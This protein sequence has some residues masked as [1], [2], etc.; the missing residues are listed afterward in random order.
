[1]TL[2]SIRIVV[3]EDQAMVLGAIAALLELEPDL[4]VVACATNGDA[5]LDHV[6]VLRPD[7]LLTD[8][9]MPGLSGLDLARA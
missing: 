5:A 9:E 1:M 7:I 6:R 4:A 2:P 3:A 8:I